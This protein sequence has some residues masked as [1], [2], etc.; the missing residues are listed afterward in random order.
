MYWKKYLL[1]TL[2]FLN[3]SNFVFSQNC[4]VFASNG[5]DGQITDYNTDSIFS[6]NPNVKAQFLFYKR[7]QGKTIVLFHYFEKDG[8]AYY[9][10]VLGS[11]HLELSNHVRFNS[12]SDSVETGNFYVNCPGSYSCEGNNGIVACFNNNTIVKL[13][14]FDCN[15]KELLMSNQQFVLS[16]KKFWELFFENIRKMLG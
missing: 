7:S 12:G 8:I 11:K 4:D 9:R 3:A 6:Q 5:M 14:S 1:I 2:F 13:T 10:N 15:L 16:N